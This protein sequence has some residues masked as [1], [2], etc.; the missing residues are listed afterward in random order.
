MKPFRAVFLL[1]SLALAGCG[2]MSNRLAPEGV[3][4]ASVPPEAGI[5]VLSTGAPQKCVST[6]TFLNLQPRGGTYGR[7]NLLGVAVDVYVIPSDF[8]E[9]YG[10]LHALVLKAGD[11]QLYPSI[12]NPYVQAKRVPKA[13]FSVRAGEVVYLGEYFQPISC[14]LNPSSEVRDQETR[15]MA[16]LAKKNP[17]LAARPYE[18]RLLEFSGC[19]LGCD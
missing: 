17:A 4:V 10:F 14:T 12:A 2:T 16:L 19:L 5:A 9:H 1:A 7:D 18:K 11:Y 3:D 6:A 8:Q 15:D 13:E